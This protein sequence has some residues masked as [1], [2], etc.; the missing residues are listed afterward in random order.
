MENTIS[1][2]PKTNLQTTYAASFAQTP[3]ETTTTTASSR[4]DIL[5]LKM[6]GRDE[7]MACELT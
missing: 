1:R 3:K 4:R 6:V 7:K 2:T 5:F